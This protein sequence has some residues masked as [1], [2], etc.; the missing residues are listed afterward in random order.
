[1]D[2]TVSPEILEATEAP[3]S[4]I[5]VAKG[6]SQEIIE[7]FRSVNRLYG[8]LFSLSRARG[9]AFI[10]VVMDQEDKALGIPWA[11]SVG[12]S[13]GLPVMLANVQCHL[14]SRRVDWLVIAPENIRQQVFAF[15]ERGAPGGRA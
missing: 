9:D 8:S 1:M 14:G 15:L 4:A 13:E 5:V 2:I 7:Q 11:S 10:T 3:C 6:V 12:S